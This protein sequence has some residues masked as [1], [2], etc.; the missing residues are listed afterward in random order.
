MDP[1]VILR[2]MALAATLAAAVV[3]I[4]GWPWRAPNPTRAAIGWA[5]GIA[6]AVLVGS[7]A[8]GLEPRWPP[9][10]N[11]ERFFVLVLPATVLA[12]C[13]AAFPK[14][15]RWLAWLARAA[16]AGGAARILLHA[17]VYLEDLE[18]SGSAR[19]SADEARL[20]LG[21]LAVAL[22]VVWGGLGLLM[23][24]APSRSVPL[25]LAVACAGSALTVMIS[26]SISKGQ[27]GLPLAAAL[28]GAA[29]ASFVAPMPRGAAPIS[30]GLV[31]LYA[32]LLGGHFFAEL[33]WQHAA[34]LFAAPL[35]CWVAVLPP[36]QKLAPWLR[37]GLCILLVAI[38][39]AVAG[40]QANKQ[41]EENSRPPAGDSDDY[42][43]Y[44]RQ[45]R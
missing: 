6:A 45:L 9:K 42:E 20:W 1:S 3:L 23:R 21:G 22:L 30:I 35:L 12:E 14:L 16:V 28:V 2:A 34:L 33:T 4:L 40:Y 10:Q 41:S 38:P 11:Q 19:W 8:L 44:Y 26:G 29:A 31:G 7:D 39:V 13:L 27:L 18:G 25:A 43:D 32:L 24:I 36:F 17:S 5:L 15:P 37:G